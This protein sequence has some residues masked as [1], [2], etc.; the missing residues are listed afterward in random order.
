MNA[1][2]KISLPNL[3]LLLVVA[4]AIYLG[5]LLF[6]VMLDHFEVKNQINVALNRAYQLEDRRLAGQI[7]EGLGR[8]GTHWTANPYGELEEAVGLGVTAEQIVVERNTV[9][10]TIR[11]AVPYERQVRLKPTQK[12]LTIRFSPE[13]EGPTRP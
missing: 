8:V 3:I 5:V 13:R 12:F 10:Q 4:S 9:A 1:S 6:P 2:G 11:I 7:A